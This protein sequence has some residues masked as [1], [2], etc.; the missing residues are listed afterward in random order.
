MRSWDA[1]QRSTVRNTLRFIS[2]IL[3]IALTQGF[4]VLPNT[5][6]H[7]EEKKL[8]QACT[9]EGVRY[10]AVP[11]RSSEMRGK[12]RIGQSVGGFMT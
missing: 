12:K 6:N 5:M 9:L 3:H 7:P 4:T 2:S 11:Y 8:L 10:S 1:R